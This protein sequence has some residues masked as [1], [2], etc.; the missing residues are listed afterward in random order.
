MQDQVYNP[1]YILTYMDAHTTLISK[2][3]DWPG[4]LLFHGS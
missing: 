3:G 2:P 4:Y 1:E